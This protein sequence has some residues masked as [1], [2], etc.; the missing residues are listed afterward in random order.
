MNKKYY[1]VEL[2]LLLT[3]CFTL[4]GCAPLSEKINEYSR[5]K[6]RCSLNT[7]N[8]TQFFYQSNCY[9]ILEDTV[10]NRD[11]GDWVGYIRQL[12]AVDKDGNVVFQEDI[13]KASF[14][15]LEDLVVNAPEAAYIIP[16]LN[17][18]TMPDEMYHLIVDVNGS[19]H[20]AVLQENI[21]KDAVIF[22]FTA[23][24][25]TVGKDFEI[26]PDNATQLIWNGIVYQVEQETVSVDQLGNYLAILAEQVTFDVD[27]KKILSK[28][29]LNEIDW[30]GTENTRRENW[31]YTDIYEIS[32]IDCADAVA[33]EVN[34]Q[35]YL[36]KAQ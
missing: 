23:T 29:E 12:A 4:N 13:E 21:P 35:Y 25:Q 27:T 16:L 33:V 6:E 7:E 22:D 36:A 11:L 18:Y 9:T 19:Y 28:E 15:N 8:V 31:F 20:K 26:N 24:D 3:L 5:D 14:Q 34:N 30:R 1:I 10:S 17:V 2:L 32:G